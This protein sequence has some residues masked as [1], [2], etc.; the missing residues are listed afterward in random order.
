LLSEISYMSD[1]P[2]EPGRVLLG[3][4]GGIAAYKSADLVRRLRDA[5]A[6]V[7]V[8]LTENA[9]RFVTAT[10]FQALSGNPV[11]SSLWDEAAEAA[12]GHIELARWADRILIAPA[13][14]DTIARLAHG[15]AN[16]LLGAVVLAASSPLFIAPA[17]NRQMW[18]HPATRANVE[19][20]SERGIRILGPGDGSQACGDVGA[21]R[22]LEPIELVR[23]LLAGSTPGL[24]QGVRV[25]VSAGP[26]YEDIDPVRY[27]GNRS[28]GRMGFAVAAAARAAG[29]IVRLVAGPVALPTPVGVERIDVRSA[30]DMGEAVMARVGDCDIYVSA[31]AVGDYRPQAVAPAKLKKDHATFA[32][33]LVRNPDILAQVSALSQRP[34]LV[35]FAAETEN[36]E[37]YARAKLERKGLDLIAANRVGAELGF[38]HAQNA[39]LLLWSG[40][41]EE[42]AQADKTELAVR[43]IERIASLYAATKARRDGA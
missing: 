34:F 24:L 21:G 38:E 23:E 32:L 26:T 28:S 30:R 4:C 25:L 41:R 17:M 43:L 19:M 27:I 22:M 39:L 1:I 7:R 8:I 40:G 6:D 33:E 35:G 36:L 18:A 20:L 37:S 10:T 16:D 11:R 15:R 31:A 5:G 9:A 2:R 12:M 29:A 42:L 14:A 3:V 13:S